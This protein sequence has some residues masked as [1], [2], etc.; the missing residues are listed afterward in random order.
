M[1]SRKTEKFQIFWLLSFRIKLFFSLVNEWRKV[2][3]N[4]QSSVN[5]KFVKISFFLKVE[6]RKFIRAIM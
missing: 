1:K 2:S 3:Q 6:T 4:N 5:L